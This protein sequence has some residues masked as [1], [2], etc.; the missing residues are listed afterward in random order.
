M[1][2]CSCSA[3]L[4]SRFLTTSRSMWRARTGPARRRLKGS[5]PRLLYWV[6]RHGEIRDDS[7]C[8]QVL[9]SLALVE[10]TDGTFARPDKA[11]LASAS[12]QWLLGGTARIAVSVI[13][14]VC[15]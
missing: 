6:Q 12:V 5:V 7:A 15:A 11:Y 14:R 1:T 8:A 2:S 4:R 3:V 9:R 13:D 10:C